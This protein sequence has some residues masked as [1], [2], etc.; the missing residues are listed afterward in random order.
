MA[1][2]QRGGKKNHPKPKPV[3]RPGKTD[4]QVIGS[5]PIPVSGFDAWWRGE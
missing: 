5:D 2:W 4:V 3:E 1:N